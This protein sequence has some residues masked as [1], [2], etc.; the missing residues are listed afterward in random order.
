MSLI[1]DKQRESSQQ[2][3]PIAKPITTVANTVNDTETVGS[4]GYGTGQE[5]QL[6]PNP[7][8][9]DSSAEEP[10]VAQEF[11]APFEPGISD[12]SLTQSTD[13]SLSPPSL[14]Q[15]PFDPLRDLD[16][17]VGGTNIWQTIPR[18]KSPYAPEILQTLKPSTY[19]SSIVTNDSA[20]LNSLGMAGLSSSFDNYNSEQRKAAQAEVDLRARYQSR[21]EN[22]NIPRKEQPWYSG[23]GQMFSDVLFGN[24]EAQE[25]TNSQG[26]FN[27]LAG[28]YGKQGAGLG[29]AVKYVLSTPWNATV[30]L[31]ADINQLR[32]N[33]LTSIGVNKET[34]ERFSVYGAPTAIA[35]KVFGTEAVDNFWKRFGLQ[36]DFSKTEQGSATARALTGEQ[37]GDLNDPAG[38]PKGV[39][40]RQARPQPKPIQGNDPIG[41]RSIGQA[42]SDDPVGAAYEIVGQIVDPLGNKIGDLA[43]TGIRNILKVPKKP[44]PP[45]GVT[46]LAPEMNVKFGTRRKPLA[47]PPGKVQG[48]PVEQQL[49]E[50]FRNNL[51]SNLKPKVTPRL[52]EGSKPPELPMLPGTPPPGGF[53]MPPKVQLGEGLQ[54]TGTRFIPTEPSVSK[55]ESL[56]TPA[57]DDVWKTPV[58]K[59][60]PIQMEAVL[61]SAAESSAPKLPG[62]TKL[63]DPWYDDYVVTNVEKFTV[64]ESAAATPTKAPRV[65]EGDYRVVQRALPPAIEITEESAELA[66]AIVGTPSE[67]VFKVGIGNASDKPITFVDEIKIPEVDGTLADEA[68]DTIDK[69]V[70]EFI[71]TDEL[72]KR[73]LE[74]QK[75]TYGKGGTGYEEDIA[76]RINDVAGNVARGTPE[77]AVSL[78]LQF[79]R[80]ENTYPNASKYLGIDARA[81]VDSIFRGLVDQTAPEKLKKLTGAI[82][83]NS[84][85]ELSA[86][87]KYLLEKAGLGEWSGKQWRRPSKVASE[88]S[89]PVTEATK[90][91]VNTYPEDASKL[92]T[93]NTEKKQPIPGLVWTKHPLASGTVRR[94]NPQELDKLWVRDR[95]DPNGLGGIGNRYEEAKA[96]FQANANGETAIHMSEITMTKDGRVL[97]TDGRHR[98]AVLRDLGFTDVPVMVREAKYLPD[99]VRTGVKKAVD[100]TPTPA[101]LEVLEQAAEQLASHKAVIQ[102]PLQQLDDVVESTVDF[103]RKVTD[104]LPFSLLSTDVVL[105][106]FENNAKLNLPSQLKQLVAK[107]YGDDV[108]EALFDGD[109]F[110]LMSSLENNSKSIRGLINDVSE[111][112]NAIVE[113]KAKAA[114]VN[115]ALAKVVSDNTTNAEAIE[116]LPNTIKMPGKLLHGTALANWKPDYNIR[117]Y[118]SRGELG[119]G[120]YVTNRKSVAEDYARALISE[121]VSPGANAYDIAPAVYELTQSFTQTFSARGKLAPS[122]PVVKALVNS[123]PEKLRDNV[124]ISLNRDKST[125][126]VGLLN[127]VEAALVR[128]SMSPDESTLK[129]INLGISE[130]LRQLGYDSVYDSKSGF[131]L[132]LDETKVSISKNTPVSK[133]SNPTQAALARYNA[134]AYAA[135][136]YGE[137]LTTDANLRDSAYKLLSQLESNV[138][139]KL[140][141][142][143][144]EILERGLD[145]QMT[146]LPPKQTF[147]EGTSLNDSKPIAADELMQTFEP[148]STNPCEF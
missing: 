75:L 43:A 125:S 67:V 81:T 129:E 46:K 12:F 126:L 69:S 79:M 94:V 109:Y 78:L 70:Q 143:Q 6:S 76:P 115:Q 20:R 10:V 64:R 11:T 110:G 57:N 34:A 107:S 118:G 38:N 60:S 27:P 51:P 47:L 88:T 103:G 17:S 1:N 74:F 2:Q 98:L 73:W 33:A 26:N 142:V 84:P 8:L 131:G 44:V 146:V 148:K 36:Q 139:D 31:A 39:L 42:I 108:A 127:K 91:T 71:D 92:R 87:E 89:T 102:A 45:T 133:A 122:S 106:A 132:V 111:I 123:L 120:L 41:L 114:P 121:N 40:Y 66:E 59:D 140:A 25:R 93:W 117:L 29:G 21:V 22:T 9:T 65:Y 58:T 134:D 53:K 72:G 18:D 3:R 4:L 116:S 13:S 137:R 35:A 77:K 80:K 144:K 135:K 54:V 15:V 28:E 101:P 62:N 49:E 141:S 113:G 112:N 52:P 30:G 104:E 19:D 119:S 56:I 32:V 99:S 86:S 37:I 63:P 24:K 97:F 68:T 128:S 138:D 48:V 55:Y 124:R 136:F 95:V 14:P 147:R 5:F 105:E 82:I 85:D 50:L 145:K 90:E 7:E 130:T 61:E 16:S 83:G 23:V 96:F 100:D